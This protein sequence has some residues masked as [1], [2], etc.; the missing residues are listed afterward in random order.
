MS[1][2]VQLARDRGLEKWDEWLLDARGGTFFHQLDVLSIIEKHS[3]STLHKLVGYKGEHPI[4]LFPIFELSKGPIDTVFSPPPNL[5]IPTLG[6]VLLNSENL[7][8]RKFEKRNQR[9]INGA[10]DWIE[11]RVSPKYVHLQP[12]PSY[13]D[14]RPFSWAE[15]DVAPR[16]TYHV[17]I[18]V[19]EEEVM[20][21][22]KSSLRSDIRRSQDEDFEIE[23][24]DEDDIR[25]VIE[26]VR[27]R[28]AAQDKTYRI[29]PEYAVDLR[30]VVGTD[31]LPVYIGSIDGERVSGILNP[32]FG[33]TVHFWQGGGKPDIS[34]PMND[35]IHWRIIRDAIDEGYTTY[36]LVGANTERLCRYKSKFNPRLQTY[37]SMTDGIIGM[38]T[39]AKLYRKFR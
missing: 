31:Q 34:L 6:P 33:S 10:L 13:D 19:G 37:Y 1:V 18:S 2:E 25:F 36:D 28:Y 9:F 14:P 16:H 5:G 26:K 38:N 11:D 15:F 39:A 24:G 22:F 7:K 21:R 35:L 12:S 17:D 30:R 4:G 27:E 29:S 32:R 20:D 23:R 3:S 8:Q